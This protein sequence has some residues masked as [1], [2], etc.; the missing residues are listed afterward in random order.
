MKPNTTA[1][2]QDAQALAEA[3]RKLI[4]RKQVE[5]LV[6]FVTGQWRAS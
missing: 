2:R 1:P 3:L 4:R 5:K 6:R